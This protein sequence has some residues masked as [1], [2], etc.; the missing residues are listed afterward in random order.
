M[1]TGS[2]KKIL[3]SLLTCYSPIAPLCRFEPNSNSVFWCKQTFHEHFS[4]T[5]S[6]KHWEKTPE[7][8]IK[9]N[10]TKGTLNFKAVHDIYQVK[11]NKTLC[12]ECVVVGKKPRTWLYIY[13][14]WHGAIAPWN[15][16]LCY[17]IPPSQHTFASNYSIIA[18]Y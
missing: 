4:N 7:R 17:S 10:E 5:K 2:S 9:H 3:N 8:L 11:K 15:W 16:F 18:I 6:L 13:T 12:N 14:A 1:V